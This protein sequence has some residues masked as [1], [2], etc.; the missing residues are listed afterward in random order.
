M[1]GMSNF[2]FFKKSIYPFPTDS[3]NAIAIFVSDKQ[4]KKYEQQSEVL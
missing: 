4:K 2:F 1:W 3:H